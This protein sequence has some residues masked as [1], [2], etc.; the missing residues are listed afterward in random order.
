MEFINYYESGGYSGNSALGGFGGFNRD[1][2]KYRKTAFYHTKQGNI[3][4]LI[5]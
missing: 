4:V 5:G 2:G 3:D 1:A